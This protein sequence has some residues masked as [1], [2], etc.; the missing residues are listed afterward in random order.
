MDEIVWPNYI[1]DHAWIFEDG[2]VEGLFKQ[3]VLAKAGINVPSGERLDVDI[4]ETLE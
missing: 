1:Q 4:S 3:D 2:N